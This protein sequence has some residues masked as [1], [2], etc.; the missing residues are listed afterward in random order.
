MT[1]YNG[2]RFKFLLKRDIQSKTIQK[3]LTILKSSKEYKPYLLDWDDI[4]KKY[5]QLGIGDIDE[6]SFNYAF[7]YHLIHQKLENRVSKE[8][9]YLEIRA[10]L[11]DL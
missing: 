8:A 6:F 9:M 5:K 4:Q 3:I 7:G 11:L 10:H 2:T 1:Y